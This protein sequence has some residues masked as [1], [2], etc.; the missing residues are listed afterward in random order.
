MYVQGESLKAGAVFRWIGFSTP[1]SPGRGQAMFRRSVI[2]LSL[3]VAAVSGCST[4]SIAVATPSGSAE[5]VFDNTSTAA[6]GGKLAEM[7]LNG[8]LQIEGQD[9]YSLKCSKATSGMMSV[10]VYLLLGNNTNNP[11]QSLHFQLVQSGQNVRVV[12]RSYAEADNVS[13][14]TVTSEY[15]GAREINQAQ[16]I[17]I[18]L[19]GHAP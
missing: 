12:E 11:R 10:S 19:G 16:A 4:E 9:A 2:L 7:C 3:L 6:L 5:A 15:T 18:R 13:G 17:L 8:G 14:Q 1:R